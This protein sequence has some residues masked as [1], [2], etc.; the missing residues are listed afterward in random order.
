MN[1]KSIAVLV[2][3]LAVALYLLCYQQK[4]RKNILFFN[5][6]S[7]ILYI[8]QYLLLGAF[9]GAALDI[10]GTVATFFAQKKDASFVQKHF[11]ACILGVNIL[12][13]LTGVLVYESFLSILPIIA[14]MMHTGSFWLSSEKKIRII[15]LL[16]TPFWLIYNFASGAYGSCI[17]DVLSMV[18]IVTAMVRYDFKKEKGE[19]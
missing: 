4:K 8:L 9:E 14:V 5:V 7:R 16:G 19:G 1:L 15:C 3:L 13:V 17:G 11:K 18:S 2:G 6:T 10:A 12:I